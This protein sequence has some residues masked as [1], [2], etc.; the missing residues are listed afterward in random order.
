VITF[1]ASLLRFVI[2]F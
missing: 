1:Y 2:T